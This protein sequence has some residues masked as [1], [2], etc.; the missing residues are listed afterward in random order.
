MGDRKAVFQLT[1]NNSYLFAGEMLVLVMVGNA[2]VGHGGGC[3]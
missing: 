1:S 3:W 2:G